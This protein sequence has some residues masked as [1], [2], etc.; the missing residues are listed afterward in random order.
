MEQPVYS[1]PYTITPI[2]YLREPVK[3]YHRRWILHHAI[4]CF[5]AA[6]SRNRAMGPEWK[7]NYIVVDGNRSN[8][9][10]ILTE[11]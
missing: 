11:Q 1:N 5:T 2:K 9:D 8:L 7:S 3:K 4:N 10:G 6:S